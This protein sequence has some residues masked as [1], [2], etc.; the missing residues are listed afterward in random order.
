MMDE[1]NNNLDVGT[2]H[3]QLYSNLLDSRINCT[4]HPTFFICG[5]VVKLFLFFRMSME[6]AHLLI[7]GYSRPKQ[8]KSHNLFQRT[9]WNGT[10]PAL[11]GSML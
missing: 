3:P 4:V 7:L 11:M 2:L 8:P 6:V 5:F 10:E 1:I 9:A